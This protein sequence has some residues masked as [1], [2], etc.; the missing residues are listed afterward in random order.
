MS[1]LSALALVAFAATVAGWEWALVTL[2]GSGVAL[3]SDR[4]W[5]AVAG[6]GAVSLIWIALFELTG[7]RR[8]FFPFSMQYAVQAACLLRGRVACPWIAGGGALVALFTA[9]RIWQQ[10][11]FRVLAVELLIAAAVLGIAALAFARSGGGIRAR[12]AAGVLGSILA[13]AGLVF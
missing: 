9:I 12:I 2:C 11:T 5:Q 13:F 1:T 3:A 8:L 7:D 6:A 4:R 10:A